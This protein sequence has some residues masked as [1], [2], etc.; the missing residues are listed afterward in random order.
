MIITSSPEL[1]RSLISEAG[2]Q[3]DFYSRRDGATQQCTFWN[4]LE[5]LAHEARRSGRPLVITIRETTPNPIPIKGG[6]QDQQLPNNN[7]LK[8]FQ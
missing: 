6:E 7:V 2:R 5:A 4:D 1:L 8:A 3:A